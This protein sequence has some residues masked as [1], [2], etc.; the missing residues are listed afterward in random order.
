MTNLIFFTDFKRD[1]EYIKNLY[2]SL[3]GIFKIKEYLKSY[4]PDCPPDDIASYFN[5]NNEEITKKIKTAGKKI[6]TEW[7]KIGPDFFKQVQE[8]TGFKWSRP[9]YRCHWS[10]TAIFG[11]GY[12]RPD[13]IFIFPLAEHINPLTT[14]CHELYHLHF[15]DNLEFLG[16]KQSDELWSLSEVV[17]NLVLE[18]IRLDG[19]QF[20][21]NIY[22]DHGE[23]Y[24]KVKLM[25]SKNF[26]VFLRKAAD[27]IFK[28]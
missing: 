13:L 24:E 2:P 17:V 21:T 19:I 9:V 6:E 23:L 1:L 28:D 22:K 12:N 5:K 14:M 10:S 18:K 7:K 16:V 26:Q 20:E 27:N 8:I 3:K 15:W 25:D 11:G 4:Y